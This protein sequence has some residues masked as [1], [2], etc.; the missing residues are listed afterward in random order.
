MDTVLGNLNYKS[1]ELWNE[2]WGNCFL[3][4]GMTFSF[5]WIPQNKKRNHLLFKQ[6][7]TGGSSGLLGIF[8]HM[9]RK[10]L[11]AMTISRTELQ[12]P[13]LLMWYAALLTPRAKIAFILLSIH[14][15]SYATA[16][17]NG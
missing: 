7:A 13:M 1:L 5:E 12:R 11:K 4:L 14:S 9:L 17:D 3:P 6:E 15:I 8:K 2:E 16:C 10:K